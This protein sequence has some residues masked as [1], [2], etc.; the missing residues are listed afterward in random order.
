MGLLD[1][2][3][4][5]WVVRLLLRPRSHKEHVRT[6]AE[7]DDSEER[8]DFK[9]GAALRPVSRILVRGRGSVGRSRGVGRRRIGA[10]D[11]VVG[12]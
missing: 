7:P 4:V 3:G 2:I 9:I 1:R 12:S 8:K 6:G 11:A 10:P 5:K